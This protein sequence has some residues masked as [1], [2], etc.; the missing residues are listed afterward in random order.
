MKTEER[1]VNCHARNDDRDS[2]DSRM[3]QVGQT[4]VFA[5]N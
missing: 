5:D 1:S 2:H 4:E 3:D